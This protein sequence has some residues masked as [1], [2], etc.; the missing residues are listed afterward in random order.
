MNRYEDGQADLIK[1]LS[2]RAATEAGGNIVRVPTAVTAQ[3]KPGGELVPGVYAGNQYS[4]GE[5]RYRLRVYIYQNGEYRITNE[6][7][8]DQ[9][10]DYS[11]Q[12]NWSY[13]RNSGQLELS[14]SFDLNN[15]SDGDTYC[16]YGRD[17]AGKATI[18]AADTIL[19]RRTTLVYDGQPTKRP[20]PAT[21]AERK[22]AA[23][24]EAA[25]FKWTTAPGKGVLDAQ[26][27]AILS[28]FD[29][30]IYSAGLSGLG[31]NVTTRRI[32]CSKMAR[33]IRIF[34]WRPISWT[35]SV[36]QPERAGQ[37][38]QVD[39]KKGA[40]YQVS[41]NGKPYVNLPRRQR[42][43][44]R[45]RRPNWRDVMAPEVRRLT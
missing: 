41:W 35:L 42:F 23:L 14:R 4:D 25:R 3:I 9:W 18:I 2:A 45:R 24:A 11:S 1:A 28:Y 10:N 30:Q 6:R 15:D 31:T 43:R 19:G 38:G 29:L 20:S 12:G 17:A 26:I 44:P 27:A 40:G 33:F 5:L 21:I 7:D 37:M 39:R 34:A 32:C 8:Q 22:A 13:N 16:Y 36:R